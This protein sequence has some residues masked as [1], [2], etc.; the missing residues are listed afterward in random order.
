VWYGQLSYFDQ[1]YQVV[2]IDLAGHGESGKNRK[3]W[4]IEAF[5]E[6][7]VAVVDK[8]DL[9]QV[10]LIGW[11][12]G[13][14]IIAEAAL[15]MPE[16]VIGLMGVDTFY[17]LN[18]W[19]SERIEAYWAPLSENFDGTFRKLINEAFPPNADSILIENITAQLLP[20]PTPPDIAIDVIKEYCKHD[21]AAMLPKIVAPIRSINSE[22]NPQNKE[23]VQLYSPS[24]KVKVMSDV[25][26]FLMMEDPM[27]FN[28]LL[29]DA[30][31]EFIQMAKSK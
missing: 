20:S 21:L 31:D 3:N 25:G 12:I 30:I 5:G 19:T 7:I 8:L 6:D 26:H 11:S 24:F 10:V 23:T 15:R 17:N 4:T 29:E 28:R 9:D 27:T 18:P 16:R 2:A 22:M 1:K 13:D 14:K